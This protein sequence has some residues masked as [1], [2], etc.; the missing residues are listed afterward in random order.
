MLALYVDFNSRERLP[1]GGQAV[2]IRLGR[3]NPVTLDK[4]LR[5]GLQVVVYD[6]DIRCEGILRRGQWV[7]GWIADLIPE[8]ITKLD[9]GEF[10]RLLAI[11]KRSGMHIAG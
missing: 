4:R 3:T 7:E 9:D 8:T 6:E 10:D 5:I 1:G 11:T 2:S